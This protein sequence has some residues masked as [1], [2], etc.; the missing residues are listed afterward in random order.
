MANIFCLASLFRILLWLLWMLLLK[1][2]LLWIAYKENQFEQLQTKNGLLRGGMNVSDQLKK[3]IQQ[4]TN[5]SGSGID[6]RHASDGQ[7]VVDEITT[8]Y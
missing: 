8:Q 5:C 7:N 4:I 6:K 2:V 1:G 3:G